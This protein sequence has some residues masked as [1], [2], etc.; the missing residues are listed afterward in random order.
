MEKVSRYYGRQVGCADVSFA[1][2]QGEILGLLGPNGAGKSTTLRMLTG[3]L[4]PSRGRVRVAGH[5]MWEAPARAR[6]LIG[7]VPDRPPIYREMTVRS[8]VAFAA[9]LRG[10]P[11]D[12][13]RVNGVLEQLDLSGVAGRLVGN[14]SRGFQQRV[15]LA[16]A[17]VHDPPVL[18]L[19]EPTVGLDPRQISE[20]RELI[21]RLGQERTVVLSS[22]ILPEVQSL[23]HRVL[24]MDGGRVLAEDTP[25]RLAAAL[26]GGRRYRVQVRGEPAA[27]EA[28]LR[29]VPGALRVEPAGEGWLVETDP[30]AD[31]RPELFFRLAAAGLPLLELTPLE[32]SLEDV[33]LRLTTREEQTA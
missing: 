25:G 5:D 7:Y 2:G 19:D 6:R 11:G 23:C 16:Q 13:R 8:Y 17:I 3:Y 21:R 20:L 1:V 15:S 28:V 29:A 9:E 12:R 4:A 14:L 27:A 31:V 22:H 26:H 32:L 24:I 30:G 18:V 10:A 33:F